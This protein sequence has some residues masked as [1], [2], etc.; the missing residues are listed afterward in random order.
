MSENWA[1]QASCWTLPGFYVFWMAL[2]PSIIVR[3]LLLR[4]RGTK[5]LKICPRSHWEWG[6]GAQ[7]VSPIGISWRQGF[8]GGGLSLGLPDSRICSF[9]VKMRAV[10]ESLCWAPPGCDHEGV[11]M[12]LVTSV[13]PRGL[14]PF[15]PAWGKLCKIVQCTSA[16]LGLPLPAPAPRIGNYCTRNR[17][18]QSFLPPVY[19]QVNHQCS[20]FW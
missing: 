20:I 17:I 3:I 11:T 14:G 5:Q 1:A 8:W 7:G 13:W 19:K 10:S 15:L 6:V 18:F 2:S 16:T 9:S 4:Y 12:G